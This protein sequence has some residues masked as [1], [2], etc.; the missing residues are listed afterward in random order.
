VDPFDDYYKPVKTLADLRPRV[1]WP[2]VKALLNNQEGVHQVG[3]RFFPAYRITK[4]FSL[5]NTLKH[6][7]ANMKKVNAEEMTQWRE[8]CFKIYDDIWDKV[9]RIRKDESDQ[10]ELF[11]IFFKTFYAKNGKEFYQCQK[12]VRPGTVNDDPNRM[13]F[14]SFLQA[15]SNLE[16]NGFYYS[17][18]DGAW[19]YNPKIDEQHYANDQMKE[20]GLCK[21][22]EFEKMF[23]SA[24]NGMGLMRNQLNKTFRFVE[25][26]HQTGGSHQKIYS[27]IL[28]QNKATNCTE[29][30]M[31]S[32]QLQFETFPQDVV[33]PS[34]KSLSTDS[35]LIK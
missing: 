26:D 21:P 19:G 34:F 9:N 31:V 18:R 1:D 5:E 15:F 7:A 11:L 3:E 33:W 28:F 10:Q 22:K 14:F 12:L 35:R 2:Y 16:N 23:D 27:W 29:K 32:K 24:I 6:F 20:M 13:W 4:E 25:Y 30:K 8:K 17:C